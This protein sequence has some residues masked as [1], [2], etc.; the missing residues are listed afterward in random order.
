M[1]TPISTEPLP[2]FTLSHPTEY[3]GIVVNHTHWDREW[4]MPFQRYRVLLVDAVDHLLQILQERTDYINFTLDGQT[5]MVEDYLE[6]RPENRQKLADFVQSGRVGLGPWYVLPD[7]FLPSAESLIR[8]LLLGRKQ[9]QELGAPSAQVG[10]L[11]DTFG[12][13]AQLP[14]LLAGFDLD[15]MVIFRGVKSDTSE[16]IWQAPD[17]TALLTIYL[18]GGYYNAM[19]LARAPHYWLKEKLQNSLE[20]LTHFATTNTVL[21]MNGCDH[22][23]AQPDT[24]DFLD[25]ANQLQSRVF[26]RQGT[27]VEYIDLIRQAKP[28][29]EVKQGEWRYNRPARITPGVLSARMYLKQAD[30]RASISL[31]RGAEPLQALAWLTGHQHDTGLLGTAWRYLLQNHPHDSICGCSVDPVHKDGETRFRWAQEIATDLIERAAT[32]LARFTTEGRMQRTPTKDHTSDTPA[33]AQSQTTGFMVF[34]TLATPRTEI[35][36]QQ[37]HF[38]EPGIN[39]KLVNTNGQIVPF[40]ELQRKP[41]KI[42]WDPQRRHY[43]CEGRVHPAV[44][45]SPSPSDDSGERWQRWAGEE[46]EILFKAN[47]PAGGYSVLKTEYLDKSAEKTRQTQ[48]QNQ[49]GVE[50]GPTLENELVKLEVAPDGS[51]SLLDKRSGRYYGPLNVFRSEADRGD[52]YS[53]CPAE[54]DPPVT[55]QNGQAKVKL[56]ESGPLRTTL[57]IWL[58]LQVPARLSED[59]TRRVTETV[60]LPVCTRVSLSPGRRRVEISTSLENTASDH[61]LRVLFASGLYN[62]TVDAQGQFM[63]MRRPVDLPLEERQRV[64][65]FDEEQEVSYHPQRAF[66]D[67]SDGQTGLAILNRGLPEYEAA[68]S[69]SGVWLELTLLRCVGWL[70]REDLS[71]RYKHAGPPLETP[72]A[73]CLGTHHFEYAIVPHQGDWLEGGVAQEAEAYVTPVYGA[74]LNMGQPKF[75]AQ[76][77]FYRLE[78]VE[79]LFSTCKRSED[80]SALLLRA[81]NTAP[82]PLEGILRL[83]LADTTVRWANL[84][85]R[86]ISET[87]TPDTDGVYHFQVRS[88]EIITFAIRNTGDQK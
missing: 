38:L 60:E 30:F 33:S 7:E 75:A 53:F 29:L 80:G 54:N 47:M 79:L 69:E 17:G 58:T 72:E 5:V 52:E 32:T 61:R 64:P 3:T 67:V 62:E 23:E 35:V 11:P 45:V 26:L 51:F 85:E 65:E 88:H 49:A 13:P 25:R 43:H 8:N 36:R 63:V 66:V 27:L 87:L 48:L 42:Q 70:S 55:S 9:M 4:Y 57:E 41:V 50:S 74:P 2:L 14:Q 16:F 73:Q 39:F 20:Q 21:L 40:Q 12:H 86:D 68:S 15:S 10:Y 34:N 46:V 83:G 56:V 81:Y 19:E 28:E 31:E 6:V 59:R 37:L 24:Q 1:L 76:R 18:P 44:V 22:F 77:S 71:T 78:P 84:A 82:Y